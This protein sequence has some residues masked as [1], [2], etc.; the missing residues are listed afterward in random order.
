MPPAFQKSFYS[1]AGTFSNRAGE[2]SATGRDLGSRRAA[3]ALA[4]APGKVSFLAIS[5]PVT[6][7]ADLKP[8]L[9]YL[10]GGEIKAGNASRHT[11][12]G[13]PTPL[14]FQATSAIVR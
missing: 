4:G 14:L 8:G 3:P 11:T 7:A 12:R 9:Q 5:A 6:Q 10:E 1:G 13:T 2:P